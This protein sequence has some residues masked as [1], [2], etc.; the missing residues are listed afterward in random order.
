MGDPFV[1]PGLGCRPAIEQ[2]MLRHEGTGTS[3]TK[4]VEWA[5]NQYRDTL[6]TIVQRK[7]LLVF[8]ASSMG[9][10][11]ARAR[12]NMLEKMADPLRYDALG[13][14]YVT[15][16]TEPAEVRPAKDVSGQFEMPMAPHRPAKRPRE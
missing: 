11:T 13:E 12:Y 1:K 3:N 8:T 5:T 9:L 16:I 7:D 2:V 10:S 6:S 4:A 15:A 14:R